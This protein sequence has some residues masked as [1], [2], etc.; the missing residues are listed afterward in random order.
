[1]QVTS[2]TG[3]PDGFYN[4]GGSATTAS[5]SA[6]TASASATYVISTPTPMSLGVSTDK[7]SYSANQTVTITVAVLSG[8]SPGSG[9]NV[10][11][12]VTPPKGG[13]AL[14]T[15]T[16]GGNGIAAFSY[17]LKR[18]ATTGSYQVQASTTAAGAGPSTTA[19]TTFTVQ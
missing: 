19:S 10:S 2:P 8:G 16:T 3:T 13:P 1:L 17:S 18:K 11:V 6:Y 9:A 14:L 5:A 4:I 7:A 12:N 15:G